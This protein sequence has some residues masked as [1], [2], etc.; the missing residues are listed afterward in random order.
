MPVSTRCDCWG[1]YEVRLE[2]MRESI[3]II[4]QALDG[5]PGGPVKADAP[6]IMLSTAGHC[7]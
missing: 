7:Q 5:M 6:K 3:K 2:E 1:R 4:Q